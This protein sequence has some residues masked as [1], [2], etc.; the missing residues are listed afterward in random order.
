MQHNIL[1]FQS[2]SLTFQDESWV[3][4]LVSY[5]KPPSQIS[6]VSARLLFDPNVPNSLLNNQTSINPWL[7]AMHGDEAN[8]LNLRGQFQLSAIQFDMV[9]SHYIINLQ[10]PFLA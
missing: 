5:K 10:G 6:L 4:M 3:G 7:Y 2:L 8:I 9:T 1:V